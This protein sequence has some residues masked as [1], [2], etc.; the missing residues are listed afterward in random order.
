[1]SQEQTVGAPVD[2]G[3]DDRDDNAYREKERELE[4]RRRAKKEF[5]K[6]DAERQRQ[7]KFEQT[8]EFGKNGN[9]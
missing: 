6:Q 7:H 3:G 4:E 5:D 2:Q 8:E 1:M 9:N